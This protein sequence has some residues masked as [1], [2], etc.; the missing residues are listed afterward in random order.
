[1]FSKAELFIQTKNMAY[2]LLNMA[3]WHK[4]GRF[5]QINM[6]LRWTE[7]EMVTEKIDI[8]KSLTY[9]DQYWPVHFLYYSYSVFPN[10]IFK[11]CLRD[12]TS[13]FNMS[14]LKCDIL[15]FNW[16]ER[17][18]NQQFFLGSMYS[19]G[20]LVLPLS[21]SPFLTIPFPTLN[22]ASASVTF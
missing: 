2:V 13:Y 21:L 15:L 3:E 4:M 22:R 1:M 16:I 11:P 14:N 17:A 8:V 6:F 12:R 5:L 10:L 18:C 20:S 9:G 7:H 19:M